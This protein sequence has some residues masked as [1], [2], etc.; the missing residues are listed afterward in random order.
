MAPVADEL[1][2]VGPHLFLWQAYDPKAKAELFS[3]AVLT[4]A[5]LLIVDPIS[6]AGPAIA[7]LLQFAAVAGIVVTNSN[8]T[9]ASLE[10]A[11]RFSTTLFAHGESLD[12]KQTPFTELANGD[13]ICADVEV[14]AIDGAAA[15][16]IALHQPSN[17]GTIIIGD[18]LINFEP[19]GFSL[20]PGKY[21]SDEGE[22]QRSLRRLLAVKSERLLFAHGTPILSGATDRLQKLLDVDLR[23]NLR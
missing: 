2:R 21:C 3:T 8:H 15:G 14:I 10:F 12:A 22:M 7:E 6:L 18:A 1:C 20:L 13:T 5:G 9:R 11:K 17:G 23:G 19:Y 16:E 4:P